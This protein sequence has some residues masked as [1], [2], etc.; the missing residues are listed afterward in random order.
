MIKFFLFSIRP[1]KSVCIFKEGASS[2][3]MHKIKLKF[4]KKKREKNYKN[5]FPV[6]LIMLIS[7]L[8]LLFLFFVG[9]RWRFR[10]TACA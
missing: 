10:E 8:T 5:P 1:T 2:Q 3:K 9:F 7:F 4:K 6:C